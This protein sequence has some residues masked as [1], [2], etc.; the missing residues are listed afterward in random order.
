MMRFITYSN[1]LP[2]EDFLGGL[3]YVV[4]AATFFKRVYPDGEVYCATSGDLPEELRP[5]IKP[6]KFPFL[7][8]PFAQARVNFQMQYLT[9]ELFN[10][11]TIFAGRDV[12]FCN[13]IGGGLGDELAVT[14]YRFHGS[15]PYCSDFFYVRP[16][17]TPD[18]RRQVHECFREYYRAV[19]WMPEVIRDS[20]ADQLALASVLG[21]PEDSEFTGSLICAP[22]K[23][24]IRALPADPWFLT[25]EDF[26]TAKLT[27]HI[28]KPN[29]P[30]SSSFDED[31]YQD[32]L[33]HKYMLHFKGN[34]KHMM[35]G[36]TKW[37][38]KH[39]HISIPDLFPDL[40]MGYLD[41]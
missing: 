14:N 21:M 5:T 40:P 4:M 16:P 34:R 38:S 20:W 24:H 41:D 29:G 37:A 3:K 10:A 33:A 6:I 30:H 23:A 11:P 28:K 18:E 25:P 32:F 17:R 12:L 26:F 27:D 39:G 19:S 22:R 13:E 15:M 36:F 9:S 1:P 35:F 2:G 31:S 8:Q 7:D